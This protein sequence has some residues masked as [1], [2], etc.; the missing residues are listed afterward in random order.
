MEGDLQEVAGAG[1]ALDHKQHRGQHIGAD[2]QPAPAQLPQNLRSG[3]QGKQHQ[4]HHGNTRPVVGLPEACLE[5]VVAEA[6]HLRLGA[7]ADHAGP[8]DQGKGEAQGFA[9]GSPEGNQ[10]NHRARQHE[11]QLDGPGSSPLE[12]GRRCIGG[13]HHGEGHQGDAH[14]S[15]R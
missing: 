4:P 5:R 14:H 10:G 6:E 1:H 15:G 2:V 11:E 13:N 3:A 9:G 7:Q 8:G 12:W